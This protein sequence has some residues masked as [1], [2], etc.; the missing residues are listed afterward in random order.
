[1]ASVARAVV[2]GGGPAGCSCAVHLRREGW[3]VALVESRGFPRVKVC[4]E[5]ISPAAT[6]VLESL[7]P[8]EELVRLGARRVEE[9]V[10]EAVV[11]GEERRVSWRMPR[12]A[13]VLGRGALDGA[14]VRAARGAGAEVVQPGLVRGV[15]CAAEGVEVDVEEGGAA[16]TLS[17]D[18]VVHADGSGRH[19]GAGSVA[20]RRGVVGMKTHL[21]L[22]RERAVEGLRMRAGRGAY[23]GLVGVEDGLTTVALVARRELLA[24]VKG[25]GDALL[26]SLW[27]AYRAEWRECEWLSCGVAGSGFVRSGHARSFRA[28]NAAG[29]VEPVGG[30]GIGLGLWSGSALASALREGDLRRAQRVYERAYRARLRWR[31]PACLLAAKVLE[32]ERL[33]GALWGVLERRRVRGAVIGR[34]YAMTGK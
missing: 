12:G 2:I 1:M 8:A 32:R 20:Q 17:A 26:A 11:R 9:F 28:G 3:E 7:V 4:G 33:V 30:E 10:L 19:D 18:I 27:P 29:A 5:F 13:W 6:G 24:E 22:P 23:T 31:R 16:R 21:R 25:D 14:L 34:W 15:R